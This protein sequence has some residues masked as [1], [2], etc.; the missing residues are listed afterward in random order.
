MSNGKTIYD[1]LIE[2]RQIPRMYSINVLIFHLQLPFNLSPVVLVVL[3][4][5]TQ[6]MD[7]GNSTLMMLLL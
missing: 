6:L 3:T 5:E 1:M 7:T 4:L 2:F